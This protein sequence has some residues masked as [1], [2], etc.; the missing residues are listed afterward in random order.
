MTLTFSAPD[1]L[2]GVL[3]PPADKS[4]THRALLLA[5]V[6]EGTSLVRNPLLTG[7]CLSTRTCPAEPREPP[8]PPGPRCA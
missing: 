7:D 4:V 3:A 1:G 8:E 5:A 2:G 6:A